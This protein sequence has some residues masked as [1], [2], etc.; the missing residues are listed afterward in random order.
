MEVS[1]PAAHD[2]TRVPTVVLV[3]LEPW[4]EVWRRNQH[5]ASRIAAAGR[6]RIVFVDPPTGTPRPAPA[7]PPG[8]TVLTPPLPVPPRAGGLRLAAAWL[9]RQLPDYDVLWV[10]HAAL[11]ALLL[12]DRPAYYDVTDDWRHTRSGFATRRRLL[13]AEALLARR[14]RT[15]VCSE[16]LGRRWKHRYGVLAEV[17]PN[18]VDVAAV[19]AAV[20]RA[21]EGPGPHVGY[22]GT[23]H[24]ERL[25]IAL[26]ECLSAS[27][28]ATVHLV[29]P[30]ALDELSRRRL[31][32]APR[33][34][35]HPP[36]P[37]GEVPQWLAAMDCLIVPHLVTPFTQSLDAIK[38][39]EYLATDKPVVATPSSGLQRV[40]APGL[41]LAEGPDF[42]PA[43]EAALRASTRYPDRRVVDWDQRAQDFVAALGLAE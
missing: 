1:R 11:G 15:V 7:T 22:V 26:V 19:R 12:D 17:I 20:P 38:A 21:L 33:V 18:G 42:F 3:S 9:R 28:P 40:K 2:P 8:V 16:E 23:L 39:W 32:D 5:L 29:G 31:T 24:A 43:V 4:D 14:A 41:T 10:N 35:L 13:R 36:V 30:D 27:L 25:D 37:A 34:V 6:A